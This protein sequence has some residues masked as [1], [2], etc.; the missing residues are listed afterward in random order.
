[1]LRHNNHIFS[2]IISYFNEYVDFI[3]WIVKAILLYSDKQNR[4]SIGR[5]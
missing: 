2:T 4:H 5:C 1:M 3:L